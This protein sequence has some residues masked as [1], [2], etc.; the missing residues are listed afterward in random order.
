MRQF[1]PHPHGLHP[2]TA[3]VLHW[4]VREVFPFASLE[5]GTHAGD[6]A[7]IITTAMP[8]AGQL[9]TVDIDQCGYARSRLADR[10]ITFIKCTSDN[11]FKIEKLK[12]EFI[13]VDGS[14]KR[15][16]VISDLKNSIKHIRNSGIILMHDYYPQ[17]KPLEEGQKAITGPFEAVE[18]LLACEALPLSKPGCVTSLALLRR[19]QGDGASKK[20]HS[21]FIEKFKLDTNWRIE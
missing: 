6:S 15:D 13:F 12:Y 11:F 10:N 19:F 21:K 14:H 1:Q 2:T 3:Q 8:N 17:G 4:I 18:Q 5:I 9:V 16:I 7:D 20:L